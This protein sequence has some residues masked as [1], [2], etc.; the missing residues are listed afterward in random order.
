MSKK[1]GEERY[2]RCGLFLL[3]VKIGQGRLAVVRCDELQQRQ[4]GNVLNQSYF[5]GVAPSV[6]RLEGF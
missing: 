5:W 6:S 2:N 3:P 4:R 1:R